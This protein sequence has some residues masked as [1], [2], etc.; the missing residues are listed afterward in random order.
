MNERNVVPCLN[1]L[2][3]SN[4]FI[5][6]LINL[7]GLFTYYDISLLEMILLLAFFAAATIQCT[8]NSGYKIKNIK[9]LE[10]YIW[11]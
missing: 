4:F 2:L 6:F 3:C 9:I 1:L 8:R 5:L 7:G 11:L 10:R